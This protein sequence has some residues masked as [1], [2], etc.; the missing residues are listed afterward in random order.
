MPQ[1]GSATAKDHHVA[2]EQGDRD[3]EA[4]RPQ[5]QKRGF[6]RILNPLGSWLAVVQNFRKRN[7]FVIIILFMIIIIIIIVIIIISVNF[8]YVNIF[9]R[10]Q[11]PLNMH[12]VIHTLDSTPTTDTHDAMNKSRYTVAPHYGI[13]KGRGMERE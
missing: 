9:L 2:T 5:K 3:E 12:S 6:G 1:I 10:Q 13:T 11:Q 7:R 8:T 4:R